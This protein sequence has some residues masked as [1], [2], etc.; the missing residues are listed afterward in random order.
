M[1]MQRHVAQ[2]FTA[3]LQDKVCHLT[4]ITSQH[5]IHL[6]LEFSALLNSR[7]EMLS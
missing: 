7:Y 3:R 1:S 6:E 4:G 5:Q 2:R